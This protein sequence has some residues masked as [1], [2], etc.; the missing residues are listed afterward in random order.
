METFL[1]KLL[2]D[3]PKSGE[4]TNAQVYCSDSITMFR[5]K[6]TIAQESTLK[7]YQFVFVGQ[8]PFSVCT[9]NRVLQLNANTVT[10]INRGQPHKATK[11]GPIAE[12]MPLFI[13]ADFLLDLAFDM[14]GLQELHFRNINFRIESH[15]A[16]LLQQFMLEC[17]TDQPGAN[18]VLQC[19]SA[20]IGI[21]LIRL[22][23]NAC[24]EEGFVQGRTARL[25]E[26]Y[27]RETCAS[28]L[29][30]T[31]LAAYTNYSP[32][33]LIRIFKAETGKTPVEYFIDIKLEKAM[34][35]LKNK[36]LSITE[37]CYLSGFN[38]LGYFSTVF[39]RK[40]GVSPSIY[41]KHIL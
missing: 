33:H 2:Q 16:T 14:L 26:S 22:L 36:D 24:K 39:R 13:D 40:N 5:A 29:S 6:A 23:N 21:R 1:Q 18:L 32:H 35:L 10:P 34:T 7:A 11:D 15:L 38:N 3:F 41:R 8:E 25:F 9:E 20:E 12:Y 37:I 19:L 30:L 31:D 4:I 27:I 28:K 17:T